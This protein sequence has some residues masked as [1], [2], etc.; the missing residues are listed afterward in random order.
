MNKQELK[1]PIDLA[2]MS[3]EQVGAIFHLVWA[4]F[5]LSQMK[6]WRT[7]TTFDAQIAVLREVLI[8]QGVEVR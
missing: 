6:V 3:K 7:A 5:N 8:S 2:K 1:A 4:D